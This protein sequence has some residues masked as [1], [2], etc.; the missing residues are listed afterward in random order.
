MKGNMLV[1]VTIDLL[2]GKKATQKAVML[3]GEMGGV[4][5]VMTVVE[6]GTRWLTQGLHSYDRLVSGLHGRI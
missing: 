6:M 5:V 3:V 2:A 4:M 1:A